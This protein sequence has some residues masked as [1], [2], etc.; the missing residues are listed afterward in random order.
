METF[1]RWLDRLGTGMNA[2]A[3]AWIGVIM[4]VAVADVLVREISVPLGRLFRIDVSGFQIHGTHEIV[5]WSIVAIVFLQLPACLRM[6]KHIRA[7]YVLGLLP[8][9]WSGLLNLLAHALGFAVF[10][11][12]A[13]ASWPNT[14]RA[15]T[16]GEWE[17]EGAIRFPVYPMRTIL[18]LGSVV[19]AL[20][21]LVRAVREL[22]AVLAPSAPALAPG[23]ER[24]VTP[25]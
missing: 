18:L 8:R 13:Y 4:F 15:W 22:R 11:V 21:F 6:G 10:A 20:A 9:A 24:P 17:G 16:M 12:I 7:D 1:G 14:V 25:P 19:L 5:R 2:V 3:T 23:L